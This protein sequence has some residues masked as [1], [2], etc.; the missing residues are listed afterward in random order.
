ML[1]LDEM[2][3]PALASAQFFICASN[4][5]ISIKFM[6]RFPNSP[7]PPLTLREADLKPVTLYVF[8]RQAV[9]PEDPGTLAYVPIGQ[10]VQLLD[11]AVEYV[12]TGHNEQLV[13]ADDTVVPHVVVPGE[14]VPG[15]QAA[16][17][18][19]ASPEKKG[20]MYPGAALMQLV[21]PAV[22]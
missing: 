12:P 9:Q 16:C 1:L 3:A 11:A 2:A 20:T 5:W 18:V 7:L 15:L 17:A 14:Y 4:A 13:A 6:H 21:D 8:A 10:A 19:V 22:G